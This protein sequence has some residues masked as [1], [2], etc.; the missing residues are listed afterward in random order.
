MD[1]RFNYALG[2]RIS[3]RGFGARAQFG[4][5]G[6]RVLLDGVPAT[7]PDGQ[8]SSTT[9]TSPPSARAEA[10][11]GP[12]S[13]LYGNASG[14]VIRLSTL[15]PPPVPLAGEYARDG[16]GGGLLRAAGGAAG[17]VSGQATWRAS[18]TRLKYGGFRAPPVRRK[19]AGRPQPSDGAAA[20]T[21]APL[22]TAVRYD[23]QNPGGLDPALLA[24]DRDQA[25]PRT[26]RTGRAKRGAR[27][28]SG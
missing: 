8:T 4:V 11:R 22:L 6:V 15:P 24:A 25:A 23:A 17:D 9:W 7:M 16:R 5:R 28:R 3:I 19:H 2:E 18:V 13:A 26:S 27:G 1:N 10:V 21:P 20:R 12:A 14:G